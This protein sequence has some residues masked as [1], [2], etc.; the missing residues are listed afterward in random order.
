MRTIATALGLAAILATGAC[1]SRLGLGQSTYMDFCAGCH[2]ADGRGAGEVA[3]TLTRQ[4]PDLTLIAQRNGGTFPQ[5]SVMTT[6]DG[7]FRREEHGGVMPEFGPLLE[8]GR[9]VLVDTGNGVVTPT[10]ER[11]VA[12]AEYLQSI[13]R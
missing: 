8:E 10:P 9:L 6:I 13:Q 5:V 12:L 11:L 4:P 2:G 3:R 7:Y 1:T